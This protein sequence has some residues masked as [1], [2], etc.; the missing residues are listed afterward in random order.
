MTIAF[1]TVTGVGEYMR[2]ELADTEG[3]VPQRFALVVP[4]GIAWD[5]CDCG[6]FAQSITSVVSSNNYPTPADTPVEPCGH[7][8]A[9]VTVTMSLLRC[10][11]TM[12]DNGVAPSVEQ[13]L[14]AARI[15]EDDRLAVR[16][17]LATYLHELR[18]NYK[19]VNYTIGAAQSVGPEGMCG[20]IEVT[21]TFGINND[22]ATC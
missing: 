15:I 22:A 19:I 2:G 21:Y 18:Q 17:G 13:L 12:N 3:G 16:R 10:V 7:P 1:A 6:Q 8:L 9:V 4:G 14:A 5:N 11:P 20:G